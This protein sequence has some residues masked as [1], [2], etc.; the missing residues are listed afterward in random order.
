MSI[1]LIAARCLS[2]SQENGI[3]PPFCAPN[4]QNGVVLLQGLEGIGIKND[5][6]LLGS[7]NPIWHHRPTGTG[8]HYLALVDFD[9][10]WVS[11]PF[12]AINKRRNHNEL[13]K[14]QLPKHLR[15]CRKD[16][17]KP[18]HF[19]SRLGLFP[20]SRPMSDISGTAPL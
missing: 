20:A 1:V 7:I 18:A 17:S 2:M 5:L 4:V 11:W 8:G 14:A 3:I 19:S 6:A 13:K 16:I 9:S 12:G 15:P 10:S